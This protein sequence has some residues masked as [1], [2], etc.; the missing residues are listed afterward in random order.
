MLGSIRRGRF[1]RPR[2][3][4]PG[5]SPALEEICLRA[6]A[7]DPDTR[8]QTASALRQALERFAARPSPGSTVRRLVAWTLGLG[9]CQARPVGLGV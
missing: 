3:L 5:L 8:Y 7:L 1:Q 9:S 6:M 4:D 2:D